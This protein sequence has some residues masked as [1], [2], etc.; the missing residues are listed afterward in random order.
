MSFA[1]TFDELKARLKSVLQRNNDT[2][3]SD[4]LDMIIDF[5]ERRVARELKFIGTRAVVVGTFTQGEPRITKPARWLETISFSYGTGVG[6]NERV[7]MFPRS[8]EFCKTYWPD[9]TAEGGPKYY[10]DDNFSHWIAVPSPD[11]DY[12]IEISYYERPEPLSDTNQ[13]N[14]FTI[15]TPDLLF[16]ACLLETPG[17]LRTDERVPTWQSQYDR[18]LQ[19]FNG[20]AKLRLTDAAMS[21]EAGI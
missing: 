19:A 12:P 10:G 4:N 11:D 14:F 3:L 20:E 2:L 6:N 17:I 16:Y 13:T 8:A 5:G 18:H 1:L 15:N 7:Q 21:R 9:L